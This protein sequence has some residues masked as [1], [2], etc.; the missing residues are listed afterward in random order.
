MNFSLNN[1]I[2][3]MSLKVFYIGDCHYMHSNKLET[4]L[5]EV[6][7]FQIILEEKPDLVVVLG[8]TLHNHEKIDSPCLRRATVFLEG[9]QKI[10]KH[11]II[12]VGNHDMD[13]GYCFLSGEHWLNSFKLWKN[14]TIVDDVLF[15]EIKNYK[16]LCVP[17]VEAGRFNEALKTKN[18]DLSNLKEFNGLI[19]HQEF[20]GTEMNKLSKLNKN[21]DKIIDIY[22][23]DA[24]LIV[25]GH[26]HHY[27]KEQD[28]FIYT[29]TPIPHGFSDF[30]EKTL[31]VI[32]YDS[33]KYTEK[34]LKLN[35]PKRLIIV[36]SPEELSEY[37][38]PEN[39]SSLKIKVTGSSE[40]LKRISKLKNVRDIE[41]TLNVKIQYSYTNFEKNINNPIKIKTNL[42]VFKRLNIE[43][44]KQNDYV[45][46]V[47]YKRIAN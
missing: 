15:F 21:Y 36:L 33:D 43:I 5:M 11:L 28:N 31:S 44:E 45:K 26:Y 10:S 27:S 25:S 23:K 2:K 29:G 37:V 41:S 32:T 24:P 1:F 35:I 9:L 12:L 4:D 18:L 34:R 46:D 39:F 6:Q 30:V 3:K 13:N 20:E 19:A 22:P 38:L 42:S 17:Y 16:F 14:T 7:I 40:V 47:F 8:D